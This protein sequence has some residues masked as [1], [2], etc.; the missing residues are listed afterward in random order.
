MSTHSTDSF[1]HSLDPSFEAYSEFLLLLL[2]K[3]KATPQLSGLKIADL[4]AEFSLS[5]ETVRDFL[6]TIKST[7]ELYQVLNKG[8]TTQTGYRITVS[9]LQTLADFYYISAQLPI[10]KL[11]YR[12]NVLLKKF[13]FFFVKS[14]DKWGTSSIGQTIAQQYL[15][16]KKLNTF[17]PTLNSEN[18]ELQLVEKN[19]SLYD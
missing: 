3:V 17:P 11:N 10:S 6:L 14:K 18:I 19:E 5:I 7:F 15:A 4:A 2:A 9:E 13:P 12:M 16:Y 8:D 1:P